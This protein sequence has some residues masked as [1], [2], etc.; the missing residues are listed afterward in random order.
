[1]RFH[2]A[3]AEEMA[4]AAQ[5]YESKSTGLG[6]RFLD[7]VGEA[8]DLLDEFPRLGVTWPHPEIKAHQE[9]R[10]FPLRTLSFVI[11]Y[12]TEP[13]PLVL[14]VAHGRRHPG[15][16]VERIGDRPGTG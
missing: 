15:Y 3:A 16:W 8:T 11:I 14:A 6:H 7:A 4:L 9:V 10:R 2:D 12:V 13:E 5:W 1:M